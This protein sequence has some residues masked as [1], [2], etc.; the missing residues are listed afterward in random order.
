MNWKYGTALLQ[1]SPQAGTNNVQNNLQQHNNRHGTHI[2]E[3]LYSKLSLSE[4]IHKAQM[5]NL[6]FSVWLLP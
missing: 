1:F 3:I 5:S 4:T 6:R 2:R